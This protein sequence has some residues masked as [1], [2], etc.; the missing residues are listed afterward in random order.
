[1]KVTFIGGKGAENVDPY[2]WG[3]LEFSLG[4]AVE[5]DPEAEPDGVRAA[6]VRHVMTKIG[7]GN[8]FFTVSEEA[9][10]D[11]SLTFTPAAPVDPFDHDGDGKPGGSLPKAKRKYQ[12]KAKKP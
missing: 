5:L 6:F 7:S 4:K 2:R 3:H 8:R 11:A 10:E 12:R 9:G 1:M